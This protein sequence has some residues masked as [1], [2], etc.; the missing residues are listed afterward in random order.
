MMVRVRLVDVTFLTHCEHWVACFVAEELEWLGF[1]SLD[2]AQ[3][4]PGNALIMGDHRFQE[5]I[6]KSGEVVRQW[7]RFKDAD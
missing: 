4:I 7:V 3:C 6:L 2:Y 1:I 5:K